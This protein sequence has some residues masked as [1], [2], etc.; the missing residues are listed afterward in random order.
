M[1]KDFKGH[2]EPSDPRNVVWGAGG[3][4]WPTVPPYRIR[5]GV[6]HPPPKWAFLELWGVLF[7]AT[8][9]TTHDV[10]V[11]EAIHGLPECFNFWRITRT[12]VTGATTWH[13]LVEIWTDFTDEP[14]VIEATTPIGK[15]NLDVEIENRS[16]EDDH[17]PSPGSPMVLYQV[18]FD[19]TN[20]PAGWPPWD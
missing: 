19:E 8:E 12:Y 16:W 20:P 13:W 15:G 4:T 5:L 10:V 7:E 14:L 1:P 6:E 17:I 2:F 9:E 18:Y 11:W 3:C